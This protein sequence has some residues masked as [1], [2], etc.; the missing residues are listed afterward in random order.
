MLSEKTL[1]YS[2]DEVE[3]LRRRLAE[4]ERALAQQK[5]LEVASREKIAELRKLLGEERKQKGGRKGGH[6]RETKVKRTTAVAAVPVLSDD[7]WVASMAHELKQPLTAILNYT[8]ACSRL[9]QAGEVDVPELVNALDQA[10]QQAER[11][12][13]L[14]QH[15]RRVAVPTKLQVSTVSIDAVIREAVRLVEGELQNAKVEL[16]LRF[17]E[18]APVVQ[19]DPVQIRLVLLNLLRNAIEAM[20]KSPAKGRVITVRTIHRS[21][22]V[23]VAVRDTGEGLSVDVVRNLFEPYQTTKPQ[24]MGLGLTLC[25]AIVQAHGGRIWAKPH[26]ERGSTFYFTLPTKVP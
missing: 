7:T 12:A 23:E 17:S 6:A 2:L 16:E 25:R 11:A 14:V 18:S 19:A 10:S 4:C 26:A 9:V 3:V 1:D 24:G 20:A 5:Q 21:A 22:D 13:E 8:Q 15:L